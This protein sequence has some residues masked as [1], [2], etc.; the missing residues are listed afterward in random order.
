MYVGLHFQ[1]QE[2]DRICAANGFICGLTAYHLRRHAIPPIHPV[3]NVIVWIVNRE[4]DSIDANFV[5]DVRQEFGI[6]IAPGRLV[7]RSSEILRGCDP[8]VL[9]Q[10]I[11]NGLLHL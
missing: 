3:R 9:L 10:I 2:F 6:V 7:V 11:A 1:F 4:N 8:Y 5:H